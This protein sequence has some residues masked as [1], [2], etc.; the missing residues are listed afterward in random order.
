MTTADYE[1]ERIFSRLHHPFISF[2]RCSYPEILRSYVF[3]N[4]AIDITCELREIYA[5]RS[6]SRIKA[7]LQSPCLIDYTYCNTTVILIDEE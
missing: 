3:S 2:I 1:N 7:R 4:S 5:L 6:R